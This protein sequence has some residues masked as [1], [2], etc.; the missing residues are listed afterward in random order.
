[1]FQFELWFR[2]LLLPKLKKLSSPRAVIGDNLASHIS[3]AVIDLCRQNYIRFICLPVN[4]TDKL[5]PLDF[6]DFGPF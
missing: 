6:S 3:P 4:S 5:Q 1:M 2:D